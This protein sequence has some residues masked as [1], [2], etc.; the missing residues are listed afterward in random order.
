MQPG[1]GSV[2][3]GSAKFALGANQSW[4]NQSTGGGLTIGGTINLSTYGLSI[5]GAGASSLSGVISGSGAITAANG[6]VTLSGANTFSGGLT[7]NSGTL[8]LGGNTALGTGT[9]RINGGTIDVTTARTTPNNNAQAWNNDFTFAGS[10]ALNL[11]TGAVTLGRA[12]ITVTTSSTANAMTAGGVI[13]NGSTASQLIKAGPGTLILNG[14]NTCT[15]GLWVKSGTVSASLAT[16]FGGGTT[17]ANA[18]TLGDSAGS[19]NATLVSAGSV[20]HKNPITVRSGSTGTLAIIGQGANSSFSGPVTLERDLVLAASSSCTLT[21]SGPITGS[22]NISIGGTAPGTVN[23]GSVYLNNYLSITGNAAFSGDITINSGTLQ[24]A[25]ANSLGTGKLSFA[26]TSGSLQWVDAGGADDMSGRLKRLPANSIATLDVQHNAVSFG[27]ADGLASVGNN[28]SCTY[29]VAAGGS[30]QLRLNAPNS[31]AGTFISGTTSASVVIGDS[32]ALQNATVSV[33]GVGAIVFAAGL[34]AATFGNLTGASGNSL[35]LE[36]NKT[37]SPGAISLTV[38]GAGGD[39]TYNGDF[40]GA[41]TLIKAGSGTLTFGGYGRHLGGTQIRGGTLKLDGA[42]IGGAVT[43]GDPDSAASATLDLN[44]ASPVLTSLS[45][46]GANS[47]IVT[48]NSASADAT[49]T[50]SMSASGSF[51]GVLRDGSNG[52]S[53]AL[54]VN[55]GSVTLSGNNSYTGG[56]TV[57]AGTLTLGSASALGTGALFVSGGT[58]ATGSITTTAVAGV[59]LTGGAGMITGPGTLTSNGDFDI[60]TGTVSAVLAG[61]GNLSKT[62]VNNAVLSGA[63]TYTGKTTISAGT[64]T[65]GNANALQ[66]STVSVSVSNGLIFG[67]GIGTFTVGALSG[68]GAVTL[69]DAANSG[70]T[71]RLGGNSARMDG[72]INGTGGLTKIGSGTQELAGNNG[73]RGATIVS[74]GTLL[75]RGAG[76]INSSSGMQIGN[77]A[78]L[79]YTSTT[80]LQV[81]VSFTGT[82]ATLRYNTS[83]PMT[84]AIVVTSGNTLTGNGTFSN[85]VT[86][87]AGA[88]ISPGN[89]PGVISTSD[90]TINGTYAADIT[91][92][93]CDQIAVTGTVAL[94]GT[95]SLDMTY[96]PNTEIVLLVN[97]ATDAVNGHFAAF[98]VNG[99]TVGGMDFTYKSNWYRLSYSGGDG[100]D[101]SIS[102]TLAASVPEPSAV[103]FGTILAAIAALSRPPHVRRGLRGRMAQGLQAGVS[104]FRAGYAGVS[105]LRLG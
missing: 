39:S 89:S 50:F 6:T 48:N 103:A 67:S 62:S 41:G 23:S 66:N 29:R 91:S 57:A 46:A 85:G 25:Y 92:G 49:L 1:A 105:P 36:D 94:G 21:L 97:D 43:I 27:I 8:Y 73:Y 30:G 96:A 79:D 102:P 2:N 71:L 51:A 9:F 42:S 22:S 104:G 15:G 52:K 81:P 68:S 100:N 95:L 14:A 7:L 44:G 84:R 24:F 83:A 77:N 86:I 64:L 58:L 80:G 53:L 20:T 10:N 82:G 101:V 93:G 17:G 45:K 13:S 32:A 75:I 40:R 61:S 65:L 19:A 47:A 33:D 37:A 28:T 11:G 34:N 60:Q 74:A 16:G 26:G 38:G 35:T 76:A 59:H 31:F 69:T 54:K 4:A 88:T 18:I 70:V 99:V 87:A 90:L 3:T 55:G 56:T 78:V 63:N 98:V 12:S 72:A 5:D